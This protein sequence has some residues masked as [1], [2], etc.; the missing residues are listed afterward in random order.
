MPIFF[1]NSIE[2]IQSVIGGPVEVFSP[3]PE[4]AI[5]TLENAFTRDDVPLNRYIRTPK[6]SELD[7]SE[8]SFLL[9]ESISVIAGPM[10]ICGSGENGFCTLPES[11][12]NS[13]KDR[14]YY[15][16]DFVYLYNRLEVLRMLKPI[17]ETHDLI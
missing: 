1:T 4:V 8:V 7:V 3:E 15:P 12:Q 11:K 6:T 5:L 9:G 16:E 17:R 14:F 13:Y 2:E 10:I